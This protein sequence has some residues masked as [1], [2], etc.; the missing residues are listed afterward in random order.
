MA[1]AAGSELPGVTDDR[2][3]RSMR[4]DARDERER[5]RRAEAEQRVEGARL[6]T[7]DLELD[8]VRSELAM[9]AVMAIEAEV[10]SAA[11]L[12]AQLSRAERTIAGASPKVRIQWARAVCGL[13][14]KRLLAFDACRPSRGSPSSPSKQALAARRRRPG[15][16]RWLNSAGGSS[17]GSSRGG[18]GHPTAAAVAV[19]GCRTARMAG[20][21][22][23]SRWQPPRAV[24]A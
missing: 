20:Q 22:G 8:R 15:G 17:R 5:R 23:A 21:S 1:E 6:S 9:Q 2:R 14:E 7:L 12:E 24:K 16:G 11:A 19:A 4:A 10:D 3:L 13:P 18:G